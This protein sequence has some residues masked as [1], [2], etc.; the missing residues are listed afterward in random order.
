MFQLNLDG[1]LLINGYVMME[2]GKYLITLCI[3]M[4][5]ITIFLVS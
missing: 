1:Y 4:I 3:I 2:V 5:E